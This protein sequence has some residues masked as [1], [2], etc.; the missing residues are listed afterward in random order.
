[1]NRSWWAVLVL[2]TTALAGCSKDAPS[3][4]PAVECDGMFADG[5]CTP[6]TE[7]FVN[8]TGLAD[9]V[10]AYT[11][12]AFS[13]SLDNGTRGTA[14]QPVHSMDNRI[15]AIDDGTVPTNTTD[16]RND[17]PGVQLAIAEHQNLP[18]EFEGQFLWETPGDTVAMWGYMRIEGIHIWQHL[19]NVTITEVA[20][21]TTVHTITFSGPQPAVDESNLR[22]AVG[23]AVQFS[24]TAP[25][26]YTVTFTD[27]T[28]LTVGSVAADGTSSELVLVAPR[29]CNWVAN[30]VLSA[31]PSDPGELSGKVVVS[32]A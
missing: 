9:T 1:M 7:P 32:T 6:H 23:D 15:V 28:D 8:L 26:D 11:S 25:W 27:C 29:T 2:A 17:L 5:V 18:G 19:Q 22:I 12:V 13:W 4:D 20:P 16:P 21:S 31:G 10:P 3:A 30:T 14:S 24:N